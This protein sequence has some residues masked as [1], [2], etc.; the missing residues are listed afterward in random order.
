[1]VQTAQYTRSNHLYIVHVYNIHCTMCILYMCTLY[2]VQY[3]LYIG[4]ESIISNSPICTIYT[5]HGY[6][7]YTYTVGFYC[8]MY[9]V[10]YT[11]YIVQCT[12]Y[13]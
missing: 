6:I 9:N 4:K 7:L 12:L 13:T 11:L 8:T 10:Q 1:M 3:T 2:I 5:G